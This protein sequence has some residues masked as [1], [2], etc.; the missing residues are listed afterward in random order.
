GERLLDEV[1]VRVEE[2]LDEGA[3]WALGE[4][5][6]E[7]VDGDE[8]ARVQRVV[9]ALL[10]DLVVFRL[11]LERAAAV[12]RDLAVPDEP[13]APLKDALEVRLVEPDGGEEARAVAEQRGQRRARPPRGRRAHAAN[14]AGA[15]ARLPLGDAREGDELAAVLVARGQVEKHV[16]DGLEPE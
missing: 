12:A 2:P 3:E 6:R 4:P 1:A 13:L 14:D 9:L 15:R 10:G 11:H 16:L 5:L 7:A 8:A